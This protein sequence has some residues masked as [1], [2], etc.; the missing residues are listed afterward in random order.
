MSVTYMLNIPIKIRE[1][2]ENGFKVIDMK[3]DKQ[4]A[5]PFI[6]EDEKTKSIVGVVNIMQDEKKYNNK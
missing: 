1:L 2:K 4:S 3:N 5:Y 6:I